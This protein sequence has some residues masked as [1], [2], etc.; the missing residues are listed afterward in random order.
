METVSHR[1][2]RN[3]SGELLRRVEA[4]ESV[5]VSNNGRPAAMIVPVGG[6]VLDGLIAR[7]EARPARTGVDRL[8]A[9]V[10][11]TSPMTSGELVED[12]RGRW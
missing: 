11:V 3:R 4:G 10:R 9:I 2:M 5:L 7:G 8:R 12:S 1:E 6:S